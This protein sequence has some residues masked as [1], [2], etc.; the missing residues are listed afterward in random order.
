MREGMITQFGHR[1]A[2]RKGAPVQLLHIGHYRF[3]LQS[4][5]IHF[6]MHHRV[7]D[8]AIVGTWRKADFDLI[9]NFFPS[10]VLKKSIFIF[11]VNRDCSTRNKEGATRIASMPSINMIKGLKRIL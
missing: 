11:P 9:H 1:N 8:E 10:M 7:K 5:R 2:S 4:F 3:I 6:A